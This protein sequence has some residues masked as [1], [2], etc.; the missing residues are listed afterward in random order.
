MKLRARIFI[1]SAI[2]TGVTTFLIGRGTGSKHGKVG[3]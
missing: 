2:S 3:T 1:Q